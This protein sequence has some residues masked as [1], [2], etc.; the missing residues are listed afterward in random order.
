MVSNLSVGLLH[1][2]YA[3]VWKFSSESFVWCAETAGET[4]EQVHQILLHQ[5]QTV[6]QTLP[7]GSACDHAAEQ[8]DSQLSANSTFEELLRLEHSHEALTSRVRNH[9]LMPF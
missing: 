4:Q 5:I 7:A 1:V 9:Y 6:N 3:E 8:E 2:K